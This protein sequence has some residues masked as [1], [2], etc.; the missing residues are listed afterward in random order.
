VCYVIENWCF[1]GWALTPCDSDGVRKGGLPFLNVTTLL[2]AL[3][4]PVRLG[5]YS[6]RDKFS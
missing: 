1:Q 5:A 3:T 2:T 4:V 6:S